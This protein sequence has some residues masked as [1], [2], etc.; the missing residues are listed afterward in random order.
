MII[1]P[2]L[3]IG[4]PRSGTSLLQKIIRNYPQLWSLPSESEIIW[5]R[6]CHPR[7]HH[8]HSEYLTAADIT[9]QIRA[10][11]LKQFEQYLCPATVWQPIEKQNL[12]WHSHRLRWLRQLLRPIY[13]YTFPI[14]Q[15]FRHQPANKKIVEKT[16][17]N[18]LRLGFVNEVFPDAKI[19][20]I[21][22]DGRNNI[23]SLINAWLHPTRF[24]SYRLPVQLNI[25]GYHYQQWKFVLP[26]G[27][28]DYIECPLEEVCAFQWQS[29]HQFIL[30]EIAKPQYHNRVLRVKLEDLTTEPLRWL[31]KIAEFVDLPYDD[32]FDSMATDLPIINS[33]DNDI[34][35]EK[36]KQQHRVQIERVMPMIEQTMQQLE[37]Q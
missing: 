2:I 8:W 34:S 20:Y 12:I 10:K 36:W 19:I 29:C 22:R 26:P 16:I 24:F 15:K 28:R 13:Q 3:I 37:Y 18:S 11:I 5:D 25:K 4:A 23:N 21:T 33:P 32:Y 6:Y 7:L 27:W 31:K 1:K 35:M 17:S 30:K 14:S 9:Q